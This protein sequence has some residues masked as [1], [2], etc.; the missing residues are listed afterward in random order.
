M[1]TNQLFFQL[2][3]WSFKW[4]EFCCDIVDLNLYIDWNYCY[5]PQCPSS[6][7]MNADG[8]LLEDRRFFNYLWP[9]CRNSPR[10][11]ASDL[12]CKHISLCCNYYLNDN[13]CQHCSAGTHDVLDITKIDTSL[14]PEGALICGDLLHLGWM[15]I[16]GTNPSSIVKTKIDNICTGLWTRI[17]RDHCVFMKFDNN[18]ISPS[19]REWMSDHDISSYFDVLKF[20]IARFL[21]RKNY[22][23]E[24][25]NILSNLVSSDHDQIPHSDFN[26]PTV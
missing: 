23:I 12:Y 19:Y 8:R 25:R 13:S 14:L 1:Y 2:T 21:P 6:P 10:E 3:H 17:G 9:N 7:R 5:F 4:L 16:K 15:V 26:V 22:V 20:K 11:Y 18:N 24:N